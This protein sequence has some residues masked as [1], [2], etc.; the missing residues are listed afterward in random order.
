MIGHDLDRDA[1]R[2]FRVSRIRSDIRFAT[3]RER[4]FR[5]PAE[6]DVEQHRVPRPWQVGSVGMA[7]V[8]VSGDTAWWVKR[9]LSD[10]GVRRGRRIRDGLREC[11]ASGRLGP[12]PER[13]GDPAGADGARREVA[14]GLARSARRTPATPPVP[15]RG[16][17]GTRRPP[18]PSD[19]S[20]R[21]CPSGSVS[22]RHCSRT[23][24]PR[25]AKIATR[26]W[27]LRRSRPVLAPPRGAAGSPVAPEPRQLRRWLLHGVRDAFEDAG[28]VHVDKELYGDVF[29]NHRS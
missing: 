3:R 28:T 2:T 23:S 16:S 9:T 17:G 14:D 6:F 29:R 5:L 8:A 1:V 18:R 10:A 22:S 4:D 13:S 15:A 27:T 25:A 19:R 11:G 7:R 26:P 12:A 20:A 24:S 21:S